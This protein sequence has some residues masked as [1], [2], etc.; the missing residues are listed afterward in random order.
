MRDP[1]KAPGKKNADRS[2]EDGSSLSKWEEE[3]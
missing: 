1:R 2:G 3:E